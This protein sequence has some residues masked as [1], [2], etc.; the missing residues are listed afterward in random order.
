MDKLIEVSVKGSTY[1]FMSLLNYDQIATLQQFAKQFYTLSQSYQEE[2]DDAIMGRFIEAV[3]HAFGIS[4]T[5][6]PIAAVIVIK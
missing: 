6:V 5:K 3:H 2:S 1:Y 4:L